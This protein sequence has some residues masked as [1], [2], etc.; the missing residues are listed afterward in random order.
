MTI[1]VKPQDLQAVGPD[2]RPASPAQGTGARPEA[3]AQPAA[4]PRPPQPVA[5]PNAAK[6]AAPPPVA[7][8]P[9]PPPAAKPPAPAAAK[10]AAAPAAAKPAVAPAPAAA[11]PAP[12]PAAKPPVP[13][14]AKPAPAPARPVPAPAAKVV[15]PPTPA[16]PMAHDLLKLDAAEL[17]TKQRNAFLLR[18]FL[19]VIF[20]TL[21]ATFYCFVYAAPR[22]VSEFQVMY[23]PTTPSG[24][25]AAASSALGSLIGGSSTTDFNRVIGTYIISPAALEIA[26]KKLDIR[27]QY[28]DPKVDW[29]D[30]MP[31]D[32]S[33]EKFLNYFHNRVVYW[34]QTGG[35]VTVDVEGFTPKQ[36]QDTANALLKAA[37]DMVAKV[38]MRPLLDQVEFTKREK[39][40][41]REALQVATDKVTEFRE[42][43]NDYS[44]TTAVQGLDTIV[45]GLNGQLAQ[46]RSQLA[47]QRRFMGANAPTTQALEGQI[48]AIE[49]QIRAEQDR[50]ASPTGQLGAASSAGTARGGPPPRGSMPYSQV[51]AKFLDLSQSQ[52]FALKAYTT[53]EAAYEAAKLAAAAQPAYAIT[54]VPPNLPEHATSPAPLTLIPTTFLIALVVYSMGS[55]LVAMARDQTGS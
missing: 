1:D 39:D 49:G 38:N 44:F 21:A 47:Y 20:P 37:D 25:A 54:F 35:F 42:Q 10:P 33:A 41:Y 24:A 30:R 45:T 9:G 12:A 3:P 40:N 27:K 15:S 5:A 4:P 31:A 19:F 18:V 48:S 36:A 26:D 7:A 43:H 17:L 29:L 11:R 46:V 2:P 34:E 22:Y 23:V 28:S 14:P 32:A 51:M 55:L 52:D 8:K 6:P 50:L 53:A 16:V 13:A